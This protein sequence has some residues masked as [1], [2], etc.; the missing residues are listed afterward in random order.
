MPLKNMLFG[1]K[2]PVKEVNKDLEAYLENKSK[3]I[4]RVKPALWTMGHYGLP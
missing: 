2:V 3:G 1:E 4:M